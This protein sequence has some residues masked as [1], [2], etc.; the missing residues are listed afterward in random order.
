[1]DI[2]GDTAIIGSPLDDDMGYESGYV[3]DL[4]DRTVEHGSRYINSPSQM[5]RLTVG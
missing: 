1:M 2:S 4:S 5:G 3:Y